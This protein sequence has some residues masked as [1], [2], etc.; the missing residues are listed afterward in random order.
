MVR[1]RL[2]MGF[3]TLMVPGWDCHGLPIEWKV[4]EAY[5][6]NKQDKEQIDTLEFRQKCRE[7]ASH[8][9]GI[10]SKEFQRLGLLADWENP[11]TTMTNETEAAIVKEMGVFLLK[12]LLYKD[13][14]TVMWSPVEKTALAEAEVEFHDKKSTAVTVAFNVVESSLEELKDSAI[15]IWT[16]TPWTLP[17]N[18]AV[19][20]SPSLTYGVYTF[21]DKASWPLK[22]AKI[23]CAKNLKDSLQEK[24]GA[25]LKEISSFEGK[26]LKGTICA[27]PLKTKGYDHPI[28]LLERSSRNR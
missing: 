25:P 12:G 18:Q 5:R 1:S 24:L 9:I 21:E 27:H 22:T 13:F 16:T 6:K 3:R 11:Y 7:F 20:F 10:Q 17:A 8:W 15:L 26:A 4:E 23:V 28:P 14:K 19:C 2:M